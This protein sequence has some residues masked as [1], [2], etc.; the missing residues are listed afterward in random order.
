MSHL[1]DSTWDTTKSGI[2]VSDSRKRPKNFFSLAPE[3]VEDRALEALLVAIQYENKLV[4]S[5]SLNFTSG[6][7]SISSKLRVV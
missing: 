5:L 2:S 1:K 7:Y 3:D 4:K 6:R